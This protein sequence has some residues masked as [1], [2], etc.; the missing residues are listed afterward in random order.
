ML[1]LEIPGHN[2]I[3]LDGMRT[4]LVCSRN[5]FANKVADIVINTQDSN[6]FFFQIVLGFD[7]EPKLNTEIPA[8]SQV[9]L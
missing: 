9:G 2:R 7:L 4:V 6:E 1:E 3:I 8:C 5:Y